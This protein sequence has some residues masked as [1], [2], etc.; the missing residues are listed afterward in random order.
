MSS[1]WALG[2]SIVLGLSAAGQGAANLLRQGEC[3]LNL[4]SADLWRGVERIAPTTGANPVPGYKA[5]AGFG[6]GADKFA[7]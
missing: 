4:V 1:A 6:H 3:T 5:K 7:L 2:S